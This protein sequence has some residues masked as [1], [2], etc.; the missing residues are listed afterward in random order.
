MKKTILFILL[1]TSINATGFMG[2]DNS[3]PMNMMNQKSDVN[4]NE[5]KKNY[6]ELISFLEKS[7]NGEYVMYLAV[8]YLNGSITPDELGNTVEKDTDK[9][10]TYFKKSI[11]L[12]YFQASAILGS[13]YL[14]NDNFIIKKDSVKKAKHYLTLAM[15]KEIYGASTALSTLYF[16]YDKDI[17]KGIEV[18]L[19]G[20]EKGVS[21]AQL[22][23]ATTF[24]YGSK[25]LDIKQ[26][27]ILANKYLGMAC[28]NK[29][30]TKKV[31]EFC[32]S[33]KVI[34]EGN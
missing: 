27:K 3:S 12:E 19:I 15:E 9:A 14:Y 20:A 23:L 16:F 5:K 21:T 17:D 29:N 25:D 8:L 1:L 10:L 4:L 7:N 24:A 13:L 32:H 11:D 30:Q 6:K 33:K 34:R 18:L 28:S 22:A 2:G 31:T 26:N